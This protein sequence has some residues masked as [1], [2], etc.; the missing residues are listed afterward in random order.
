MQV[1]DILGQA[2]DAMSVRRVFGEP[3]ERDG[4]T[5]IPV[6]NV[7]GGG[8]GG[9]GEGPWAPAG[10]ADAG[11]AT[12]DAEASAE[13][14]GDAASLGPPAAAPARFR[15]ARDPGRG[16]RHQGRRVRWEPAMDLTRVAIMGQIV[17]HRV[18]AGPPLHPDVPRQGLSGTPPLAHPGGDG[19]RSPSAMRIAASRPAAVSRRQVVVPS[20]QNRASPTQRRGS[21][22]DWPS[23]AR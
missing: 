14:A 6:A 9:W 7:I 17:G 4:L 12:E 18:P 5:I 10:R 15:C 3:I 1:E 19:Q 13:G 20:D 11:T 23:D 16:L 22:I 21:S 8:G 2:R